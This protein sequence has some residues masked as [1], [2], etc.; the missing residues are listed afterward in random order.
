MDDERRPLWPWIA[1]LLIGLPALYVLS[2]GPACW[3]SSRKDSGA[4]MIPVVYA[5]IVNC[6]RSKNMAI[7]RTID[8]LIGTWCIENGA[9]LLHNDSD[10]KPM[11]WFLGLIEEPM[12]A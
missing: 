4:S 10:F 11:A 9:A 5:P 6:L 8:L 1:A 12:A 2:F 7:R 3:I